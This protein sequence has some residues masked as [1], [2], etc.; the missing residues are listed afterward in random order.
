MPSCIISKRSSIPK[1]NSIEVSKVIK[2]SDP[3]TTTKAISHSGGTTIPA[4]TL[5]ATRSRAFSAESKAT[6]KRIAE[7]GST[8]T[9]HAWT[10]MV[11]LSGQKSTRLK[12]VYQS[13][14]S[15]IRIFN[16][17]LD[18]TPTSSSCRHSSD[19]YVFCVLFQL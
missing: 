14:P 16:S 8:L 9:S 1:I 2:I 19:Y 18:G 11:N 13:R 7:R 4:T 17:E 6:V 12:P 10:P 5:T 3:K 15:R